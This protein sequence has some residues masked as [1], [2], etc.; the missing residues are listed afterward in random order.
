MLPCPASIVGKKAGA[1]GGRGNPEIPA[2]A[3]AVE[4]WEPGDPKLTSHN[5]HA[6]SGC[7]LDSSGLCSYFC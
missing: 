5:L 4:Q 2:A 1:G 3:A 7:Q 6:S